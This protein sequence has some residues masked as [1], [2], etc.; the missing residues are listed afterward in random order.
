MKCK[1][2]Q[3]AILL[4]NSI[5]LLSLFLFF[6]PSALYGEEF[7]P[8]M[9]NNSLLIAQ[10]I[11][12]DFRTSD[13]SITF[14]S[15]S[16]NQN[17]FEISGTLKS[18]NSSIKKFSYSGELYRIRF[19]DG[20]SVI[21]GTGNGDTI[22]NLQLL[23]VLLDVSNASYQLIFFDT[24]ENRYYQADGQLGQPID[25]HCTVESVNCNQQHI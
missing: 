12:G 15:F 9:V 6:A 8:S 22:S 3:S 18:P 7:C 16:M 5:M 4:F 21:A 25:H 24:A 20:S 1:P 13:S 17:D 2:T 14:D 11:D 23:R 19:D 10:R